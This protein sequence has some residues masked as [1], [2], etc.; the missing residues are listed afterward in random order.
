MHT[1]ILISIH[2]ICG[3]TRRKMIELPPLKQD[4]ER[5]PIYYYRTKEQS[6]LKLKGYDDKY[7]LLQKKEGNHHILLN[8]ILGLKKHTLIRTVEEGRG[9][10]CRG[11]ERVRHDLVG[12]ERP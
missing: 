5:R 2:C 12:D 4:L 7:N 10:V 1:L 9:G 6:A 8:R 3:T 11:Q